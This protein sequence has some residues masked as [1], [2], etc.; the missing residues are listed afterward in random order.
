MAPAVIESLLVAVFLLVAFQGGAEAKYATNLHRTGRR[1]TSDSSRPLEQHQVTSV[2]RCLN[3]CQGATNCVAI[4]FGTIS[5]TANCQ[6]LGQRACDGL[7]LVADAAV[8]YY[9]VYDGPQNLTTEAKTPF[10]DDPSCMRGGYCSTE[11][12]AEAVGQFCTVDAHCTAKLKPP[13]GHQ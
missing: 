10:W 2:N 9:D 12:A 8:D 13:R 11:C 7:P 3:L 6:L 4:N 1:L 5:A